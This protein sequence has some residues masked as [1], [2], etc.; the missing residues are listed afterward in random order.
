MLI[1][2]FRH[3]LLEILFVSL[4]ALQLLGQLPIFE[5]LKIHTLNRIPLLILLTSICEVHDVAVFVRLCLHD[6]NE[7]W[8]MLCCDYDWLDADCVLVYGV[9]CK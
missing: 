1:Q 7:P 5:T 6:F 2:T 8:L 3:V 4:I 9:H